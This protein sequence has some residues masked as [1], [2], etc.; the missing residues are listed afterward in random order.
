MIIGNGD[1]ASA[2]KDRKDLLFFASGVSNSRE[3]RESEYRREINL[4]RK[5]NRNSHIVYFS[6]L[7]VYYSN[8]R[9]A[10]HKRCMERL[11]KGFRTWTII[12]IGNIDWGTNPY[13]LINYLK[14]RKKKGQKLHIENVYR[15]VINREEFDYWI[16]LIR[17]W[18]CEMNIPGRRMKVSE[19]VQEY[20][21]NSH[22]IHNS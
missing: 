20:V 14:N 4:L 21:N 18:S 19:I 10:R 2:I 13:T 1:I 15:Y 5:Q 7:C 11:V 16:N 9:Y 8:T 12:R 22:L 17:P 3:T 6:S